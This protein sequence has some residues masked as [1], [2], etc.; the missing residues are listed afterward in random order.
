MMSLTRWRSVILRP[1]LALFAAL[2][3]LVS[4][5]PATQAQP[6][7]PRGLRTLILVRHGV[8]DETDTRGAE[9][10]KALLPEGREQARITGERLAGWPQ[11]V[12]V[13]ATPAHDAGAR[14]GRDH[15][16]GPAR[17]A[18]ARR[19][20]PARVRASGLPD[21]RHG[22]PSPPAQ[23][24]SCA[25]RID[26][27]FARYFRPSPERDST[28]VLVCHGNVIRW[29]VCRAMGAD[30]KLWLSMSPANCSLTVIQVRANGTFK[31]TA[32]GDRGHLPVA[33]CRPGRCRGPRRRS[34]CGGSGTRPR[35]PAVALEVHA[36]AGIERTPSFSSRM[37]CVRSAPPAGGR[38]MAPRTFTTRCHG[39][40]P[41]QGSACRA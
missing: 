1:A 17:R 25:A 35:P 18:A 13:R 12:D 2:A 4:L 7:A 10:G 9:I 40:R 30:P 20:G 38:L 29:L 39:A 24:D 36:A 19:P 34:P 26:G 32:V 41:S 8:Y 3:L 33:L 23:A 5:S 27:D 31:I 16:E 11:R 21:A 37:R 28:E 15:R 22:R 6:P 14:D